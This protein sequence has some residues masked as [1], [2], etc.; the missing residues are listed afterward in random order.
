MKF[1]CFDEDGDGYIKIPQEVEPEYFPA[2]PVF[3]GYDKDD[4]DR[5]SPEE[6][7]ELQKDPGY[8]YYVEGGTCP[9]LTADFCQ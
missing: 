6:F 4:D 1:D 3:S 7:E 2:P 5:F 8:I 9:R